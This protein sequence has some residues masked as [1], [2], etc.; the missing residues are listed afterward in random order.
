MVMTNQKRP[1]PL[2]KKGEIVERKVDWSEVPWEIIEYIPKVMNYGDRKHGKDTWKEVEDFETWFFNK[3][4]RHITSWK[5]G[6]KID[7]DSGYPALAHAL[8]N[9]LMIM[10]HDETNGN[11]CTINT[12]DGYV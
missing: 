4:M 3:I 9:I 12:G 2:S 7:Q 5:N 8:V 6:N 11:H 1:R 10:W